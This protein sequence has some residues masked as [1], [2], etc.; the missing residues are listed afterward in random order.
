[1]NAPGA[2]SAVFAPELKRI[3]LMP[4]FML[5]NA[6]RKAVE[7]PIYRPLKVIAGAGTGKT[8]VLTERFVHIVKHHQ[9]SP[10]R[11][12]ALTFTR[13]AAAEMEM[14]IARKL[15]EMGLLKRSEAPLLLWVGNFHSVCL[16][17]LRQYALLAELDPSFATIDDTEQRLVLT[18]V[19]M[20]FLNYRLGDSDSSRFEDLMIDR[21]GNFSRNAAIAVNKL[22]SQYFE[23]H[24]VQQTL[25]TSLDSSYRALER[26]LR[27]TAGDQDIRKSDRKKAEKRLNAL[28]DSEA[29]DLLLANAMSVIC[30]EYARITGE[31]DVLDFNDLIAYTCR[32]AAAEPHLKNRFDYILVDEFQ[33]TDGAQYQ[34]LEALSDGLQNVTV[35]CDRKQAI[36]EWRE[37]KIENIENFPGEQIV[38]DENYR[39]FGEILDS[40]NNF[41]A[42]TMADEKALIPAH[43]GGHGRAGEPRVRLY[44]A[45]GA[46][47]EADFVASE[48]AN[49]LSRYRAADIAILMR[50]VRA[51]SHI[52]DRLKFLGIPYVTVGGKGFHDLSETKDLVALLKLV[53]NPFDDLSMTRVLK[54]AI[55]G[56]SDATLYELRQSCKGSVQSFYDALQHFEDAYASVDPRIRTRVKAALDAIDTL[57]DRRWSLTIGET[58]SELLARTNYLKYL[59][60]LE[61]ARGQRFNNVSLFYKTAALFEERNPGAGLAE[62]LSYMETSIEG[63]GGPAAPQASAAAVQIMTVHQAKGLEFP[64]VFVMNLRK[65]AFPLSFRAGGFG[66]DEKFGLYAARLPDGRP[67]ARYEPDIVRIMRDRQIREENRIM[68]VAMTRAEELL[69]LT[70]P[71][72]E[73][74]D[75]FFSAV[76]DFASTAGTGS[77]ENITSYEP[78]ERIEDAARESHIAVAE[79]AIISAARQAVARIHFAPQDKVVSKAAVVTLSYSRLSLFRHCPAKY[80][81]RYIYNL[82]LS[83]HEESREESYRH[84]DAFT[85]GNLLHD[86]LM[87]YHRRLRVGGPA[88]AVQ[89]FRSLSASLPGALLGSAEKMLSMYMRHPLSKTQ[90]LYEEEEFHWKIFEDGVEIMF[91][92][93]ID[94]IH[95]EGDSLKI[96]DYKTGERHVESHALQ[97]GIYKMALEEA[98]GEPNILAGNFYLATGEE[99]E[100]NFSADELLKIREE[101]VRDARRISEGDFW[102]EKGSRRPDSHC[103]E[104]GYGIFCKEKTSR[105]DTEA[106]EDEIIRDRI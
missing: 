41:I 104:C 73:I 48:I 83:P 87:L 19:I 98:L 89:I 2:R 42:R 21:I 37:A 67:S 91:E 22:K 50:S 8:A 105:G 36:Y 63:D 70:T 24:K 64:V 88:D 68:Y 51:S 16:T 93:K 33:D 69:Y 75:D 58:V 31:R 15:L 44:R 13:K 20:D 82:P 25:A 10:S 47:E 65:G 76:E 56:L 32:F 57:A 85:V 99:V 59:G 38:L 49:L 84:I 55:V 72:A 61:G 101:I 9:I 60:Y 23:F 11:I 54:S 78:A 7:F 103:D 26:S 45:S 92:G 3:R 18:D 46:A 34:L 96:V 53:A 35:V 52:E 97:L 30:R 95:R 27:N 6:Q 12:L 1:M 81:L 79:G 77:A 40:A 14:R 74:E 62:F 106:I 29:R 17:L 4:D 102:S 43:D 90:T 100:C 80:A 66:Y 28:P 39:S 5:N 71:Q 86:T 94:R